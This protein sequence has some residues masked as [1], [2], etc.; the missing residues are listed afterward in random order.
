MET[1]PSPT[2]VPTEYSVHTVFSEC[3]EL[4]KP[5]AAVGRLVWLEVEAQ[6]RGEALVLEVG[7]LSNKLSWTASACELV[8]VQEHGCTARSGMLL[9]NRRYRA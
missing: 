1:T 6:A 8:L 3:G 9:P 5:F 7:A 2:R 4:V